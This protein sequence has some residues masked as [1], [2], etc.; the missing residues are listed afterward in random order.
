MP[1]ISLYYKP[2]IGDSVPE[3]SR[4]DWGV[5]YNLGNSWKQIRK[6]KRKNSSLF[7]VDV[8]VYPELSLKNLV[9]TRS[10]ERRVG[11]ECL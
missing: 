3:A 9:I 6:E 4:S 5:S 2:I 10:E 1:Q 11:K 7:K 8:V